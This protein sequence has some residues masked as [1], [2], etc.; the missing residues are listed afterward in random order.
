[1]TLSTS[2]L[3][4]GEANTGRWAGLGAL[5]LSASHRQIQLLEVKP[6]VKHDIQSSYWHMQVNWQSG[7]FQRP[8]KWVLPLTKTQKCRSGLGPGQWEEGGRTQRSMA[9]SQ[10]TW[11]R[12]AMWLCGQGYWKKGPFKKFRRKWGLCRRKMKEERFQWIS[13][14]K[15]SIVTAAAWK[16]RGMRENSRLSAEEIS[17]WC[18]KGQPAFFWL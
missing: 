16:E 15:L 10:S 4:S 9:E 7:V 3:C 18:G 11:Q 6:P 5:P 8:K 17:E 12:A 2:F 13:G 14:R 1:M